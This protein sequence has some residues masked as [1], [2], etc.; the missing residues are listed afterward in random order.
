MISSH[1]QNVGVKIKIK[2]QSSLLKNQEKYKNLNNNS[3]GKFE[4]LN[5]N[6][7]LK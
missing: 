1:V 4:E 2:I 3:E 7:M 6:T 5:F